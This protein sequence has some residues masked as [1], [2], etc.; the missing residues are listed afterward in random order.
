V[1]ADERAYVDLAVRLVHDGDYSED[2]EGRMR[3]NGRRLFGD[4]EPI[5]ALEAFLEKAAR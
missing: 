4:L 3:E 5:H 1:A 2:I